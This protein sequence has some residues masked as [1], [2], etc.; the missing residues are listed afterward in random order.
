MVKDVLSMNKKTLSLTP[1]QFSEIIQVIQRG[2]LNHRPAPHLAACLVLEANLGLR[3]SDIAGK[4][5]LSDII[6]DGGRYRLNIAEQK[7]G[8]ERVFTV[9]VAIYLYMQRYCIE[10]GIGSKEI[11]FPI[12]IRAVQQRLQD[13]C[14]YLGLE[15]IGT[16]SFR[17]FF[18]TQIYQ[19][20]GY[21]IALVQ[22]L[23]QHS[24]PAI[25]QRYIGIEPQRIEAALETHIR[26]PQT[27][28][29]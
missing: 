25:T 27:A 28:E 1:E 8:K 22:T 11:M 24:S 26:L 16:H 6:Q 9:P 23:L 10:Q 20:N 15:G 18:A 3:I 21:D 5:R 12:S 2:F 19:N 13:A 7:T 14:D 29:S 4:L 17:K